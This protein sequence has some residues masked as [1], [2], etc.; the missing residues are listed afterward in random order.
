MG[1]IKGNLRKK[2]IVRQR[3]YETNISGRL[4]MANIDTDMTLE[5]YYQEY[6][7]DPEFIAEGLAIKVTEEMLGLL[8][9]INLSQSAL[10]E[11]MGVSRAHISRILNAAPNMT[12]LTIA[13]IAVA[14]G[15]T[16]D[17]CLK[18]ESNYLKTIVPISAGDVTASEQ[19]ISLTKRLKDDFVLPTTPFANA[20]LAYT[21]PSLKG[22]LN[23]TL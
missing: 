23:A 21:D 22:V 4:K 18:N 13:K 11:K 1:F 10:A 8:E 16:P 6:T 7:N 19:D 15:V 12:L 3:E 5:R 17:V 9:E 14:L 20:G 2:S